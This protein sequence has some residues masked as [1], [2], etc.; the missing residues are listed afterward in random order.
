MMP[1][2]GS[3]TA[4]AFPRP[5]AYRRDCEGKGRNRTFATTVGSNRVS[6]LAVPLTLAITGNSLSWSGSRLEG[7]SQTAVTDGL[8]ARFEYQAARHGGD[9]YGAVLEVGSDRPGSAVR[10]DI[11]DVKGQKGVLHGAGGPVSKKSIAL[12]GYEMPT[13]FVAQNGAQIDQSAGKAGR[14]GR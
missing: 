9:V 10:R 4:R 2:R 13:E 5:F 3:R 14:Y 12:V 1:F 11:A 6:P 8:D 7:G